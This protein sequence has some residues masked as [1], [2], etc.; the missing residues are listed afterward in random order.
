MRLALVCQ[1]RNEQDI[2]LAFLAHTRSLFDIALFSDHESI[3][4][5][6]SLLDLCCAD[7]PD[8][9]VYSCRTKRFY[10]K[11]IAN[12]LAEEA[13]AKG[14]DYVFCLDSDEFLNFKSRAELET[15]LE[16]AN[17]DVALFAWKNCVVQP[18]P[19]ESHL[20]DLSTNFFAN[21]DSS[22]L[23][24]AAVSKRLHDRLEGLYELVTGGHDIRVL[25]DGASPISRVSCGQILHIP[26]RSEQQFYAKVFLGA[27]HKLSD[28]DPYSGESFHYGKMLD[29]LS[30]NE[31]VTDKIRLLSAYYGEPNAAEQ[32]L[33]SLES[34]EKNETL[35]LERV[36][37]DR[38]FFISAKKR[39]A[40][41]QIPIELSLADTVSR[42]LQRDPVDRRLIASE[43][44]IRFGD[45]LN[46]VAQEPAS[47]EK[48]SGHR[49]ESI[50]LEKI[51][52]SRSHYKNLLV[53]V[54]AELAK[55][56]TTLNS[57]IQLRGEVLD[58]KRAEL[59]ECRS[60]IAEQQKLI[61]Q[62]TGE[63]ATRDNE[64]SAS[65]KE[66]AGLGHD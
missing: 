63:L 65:A 4:Q 60:V 30:V 29:S 21:K 8:F 40:F 14:A 32:P 36:S 20:F 24:K 26:I 39:I 34:F 42:L 15:A 6:R 44:E 43:G 2:L 56:T 41:S 61:D 12:L 54:N 52:Q 57:E 5:T 66:V 46:S 19:V 23:C 53:E 45:W 62:L 16:E 64:S 31:S 48:L 3:D 13:F 9:F 25:D 10:Q 7:K 51:S 38:E 28:K 49:S 37:M 58:R 35:N 22:A 18:L 47:Q 11:A 50:L 27:I 55:V 33:A 59:K 1:V 17:A